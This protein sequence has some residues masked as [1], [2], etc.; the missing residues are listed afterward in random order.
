MHMHTKIGNCLV[1]MEVVSAVGGKARTFSWFL[2]HLCA[3]TAG[4]CSFSESLLYLHH[5]LNSHQI[6]MVLENS[7]LS[8]R[9]AF[10]ILEVGERNLFLLPFVSQLT[11][12]LWLY[13][14][15]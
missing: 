2:S 15:C 1:G 8:N 7:F 5:I 11:G 9:G 13:S 6:A 10:F 14:L 3:L 4:P 12:Y